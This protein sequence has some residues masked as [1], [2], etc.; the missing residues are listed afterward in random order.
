MMND[1]LTERAPIAVELVSGSSS[2]IIHHLI[3]EK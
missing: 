2:F 3:E 1:E